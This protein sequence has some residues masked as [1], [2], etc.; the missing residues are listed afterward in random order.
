MDKWIV[1][2]HSTDL[3]YSHTKAILLNG[4]QNIV[5]TGGLSYL[6]NGITRGTTDSTRVGR[7]IRLRRLRAS[8]FVHPVSNTIN[9]DDGQTIAI[10]WVYD[11]QSNGATQALSDILTRAVPECVTANNPERYLILKHLIVSCSPYIYSGLNQF[12]EGV[13]NMVVPYFF[14][15]ELDLPTTYNSGNAGTIADITSG[16][17]FMYVSSKRNSTSQITYENQLDFEDEGTP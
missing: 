15:I 14:E 5:S 4:G 17:L 9:V 2:D 1:V 6:I 13:D 7:R 8:G 10:L 16:A 11:R 3:K 12:S